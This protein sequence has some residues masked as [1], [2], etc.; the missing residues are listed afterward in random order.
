MVRSRGKHTQC[1]RELYRRG[2]R[3]LDLLGRHSPV[4]R[5]PIQPRATSLEEKC[6]PNRRNGHTHQD[7]P[8][9]LIGP[10]LPGR[11][12][13]TLPPRFPRP[14]AP[15]QCG[16][17]STKGPYAVWQSLNH[18]SFLPGRGILYVTVVPNQSYAIDA[19][20]DDTTTRQVLATLR[21]MLGGDKVP[22]PPDM[23]VSP[24]GHIPTGLRLLIELAPPPHPRGTHTGRASNPPRE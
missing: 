7:I 17:P 6:H 23:H 24:L 14:R 22:E 4:R 10:N 8:P 20:D 13:R 3:H 9:V 1:R 2:L 15:T 18:D 19:Q 11:I 21:E 5:Y 16:N 12:D